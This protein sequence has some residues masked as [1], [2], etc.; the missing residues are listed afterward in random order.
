MKKTKVMGILAVFAMAQVPAFADVQLAKIFSDNMV[1]QR[2]KP[3]PVWGTAKPDEAVTVSFNGATAAATAAKNGTWQATLP[4][5]DV[6]KEGREFT[7]KGANTITLKNVLVGDVWLCSGQSN[8]EMS[9]SWHVLN[10]DA[11]M[12]EAAKYPNIRQTKFGHWRALVPAQSSCNSPWG[13]CTKESLPYTTACGYFFAREINKATGIP[14]GIL[15]D[16]WSGC[17]IEPFISRE[18]F[19]TVPELKMFSD[20]IEKQLGDME[21]PNGKRWL[22]NG[23]NSVLAWAQYAQ[24]ERN[25]GRPVEYVPET[26]IPFDSFLCGQYNAMIAPIGR[27]PIAGALWYQGCSNGG[28]GISY[29]QK[30]QALVNGWRKLWGC[31]FPFYIVQLAS[32]T[33]PTDDP[34]GGNGYA[35]IRNAERMAA[36]GIPLSGLAVTINIGNAADIHPK[37]KLDVGRRLSLWALRDVYGQK[38]IVVS[39]PLYKSVAV[40]GNKL[41]VSFEYTGSGLMAAAKD[42]NA[43]GVAPVPAADGKLKGFAIAGADKKWVW[44]DAVIDGATVVV[45]SPAVA[46]PVAVRY[47][48]RANPMG[49]C[50]LYN[51]EN[52]PASPFRSDNW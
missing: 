30:L 44:A 35:K 11:E 18:G 4:A 25:A 7:V 28:E 43:P 37:N 12:A 41:R 15:D 47:A 52:L 51:K 40:E 14:I 34:E 6:L 27:F 31:Q 45:S 16:N 42:P 33:A 32:F 46:S 22:E 13:V 19:A 49:A 23:M 17:C 48:F 38:D 10:G 2:G 39:G 1:L 29:Y 5:Q 9:F 20:R 50:N 21:S 24:A 26:N 8:M 36:M 3:L